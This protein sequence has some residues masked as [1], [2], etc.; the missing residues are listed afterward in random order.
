M[1]AELAW[2]QLLTQKRM[3]VVLLLG[4]SSGLPLGLT[5]TT[6][7]AWFTVENVDLVTIG[8]LGLVGQ[9]YV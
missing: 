1:K 8:F 7:Q 6:L 3:F 4:F 9:P 2:Y 5:M